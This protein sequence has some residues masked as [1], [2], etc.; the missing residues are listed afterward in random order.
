MAALPLVEAL[1]D[2]E[3]ASSAPVHETSFTSSQ[4]YPEHK[5]SRL[6]RAK[7]IFL[8]TSRAS[9]FHFTTFCPSA[10]RWTGKN[11]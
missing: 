3:A 11:M 2:T 10:H 9:H 7:P 1:E 5:I 8:C 4:I 6:P